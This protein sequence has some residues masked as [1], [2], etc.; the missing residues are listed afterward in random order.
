MSQAGSEV[1]CPE[2]SGET[3]V[4]TM[5]DVRQL[6]PSESVAPE[7]GKKGSNFSGAQSALFILGVVSILLG[8]LI[9]VLF[10]INAKKIDVSYDATVAFEEGGLGAEFETW[11]ASEAVNIWQNVAEQPLEEWK[12]SAIAK[13][14]VLSKKTFGFFYMGLGI[15]AL[16]FVLVG[17][18]LA[19]KPRQRK[20]R[21]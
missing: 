9:S 14:R 21:R 5:R 3:S 1:S 20:R 19:L 4:G 18:S 12:E 16:G 8:I 11:D 13:R 10:Y 6:E 7:V 15:L 2:C 17:S